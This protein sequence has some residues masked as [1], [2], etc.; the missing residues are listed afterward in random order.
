MRAIHGRRL[1]P[2]FASTTPK[3]PTLTAYLEFLGTGTSVG[4]PMIG[5]DCATCTST[6]PR[7]N[8]LRSSVILHLPRGNVLVDTAPDLRT[9]LLRAGVGRIEAALKAW[10]G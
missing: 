7:N 8:R 9:Q 2:R 10:A 1:G 6:D 5:C 3:F 4:V